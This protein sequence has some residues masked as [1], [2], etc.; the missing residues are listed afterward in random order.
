M[1]WVDFLHADTN[2]GKLK[3][4]FNYWVGGVKYWEGHVVHGALKLAIS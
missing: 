2:S 3:V 4:I 1:N